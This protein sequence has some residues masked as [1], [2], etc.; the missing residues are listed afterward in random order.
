MGF[1]G[2]GLLSLATQ[3]AEARGSK[4]KACLGHRVSSKTTL[5][6]LVRPFL[7]IKSKKRGLRLAV[8]QWCLL[9]VHETLGSTSSTKK[10]RLLNVFPYRENQACRPQLI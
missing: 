7:K 9:S 5:G 6:N 8:V 10:V 2:T 1:A 3:M 4:F